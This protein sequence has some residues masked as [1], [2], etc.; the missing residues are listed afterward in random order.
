[1]AQVT[2]PQ[3]QAVA[4]VEQPDILGGIKTGMD[5]AAKS[6]EI[7]FR[8]EQLAEM[9]RESKMK[10]DEFN[11]NVLSGT[12]SLMEKMRGRSPKAKAAMAKILNRNLERMG[13]GL[14]ET[15]LAD[16]LEKDEGV[17][18]QVVQV[19]SELRE[20]LRSG[21]LTAEQYAEMG[22]KL[23]SIAMKDGGTDFAP[24]IK[25]V[26][27]QL[28]T[29]R[30]QTKELEKIEAKG[31][32]TRETAGFTEGLKRETQK[33]AQEATALEKEKDRKHNAALE[34]EKLSEGARRFNE[35]LH[36]RGKALAV[37][38]HK[39][40]VDTEFK[41]SKLNQDLRKELGDSKEFQS[42]SEARTEAKKAITALRSNTPFGDLS[43]IFSLVKVMDPGSV[44]RN[45]EVGQIEITGHLGDKISN[46]LNKAV[47][48]TRI[49][50]EEARNDLIGVIKDAW[51]ERRK[52]Y[53]DRRAPIMR[54]A[55]K[56]G[57]LDTDPGSEMLNEDN[58]FLEQMGLGPKKKEGKAPPKEE[59]GVKKVSD[60]PKLE[61]KQAALAQQKLDAM[62]VAIDSE[63]KS[64]NAN[65]QRIAEM[66]R[67]YAAAQARVRGLE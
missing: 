56:T 51:M 45:S 3:A 22:T 60:K 41:T 53:Q 28:S 16:L 20:A 64:A 33:Q 25:S 63:K 48:G 62:R 50:R 37:T 23:S 32:E 15:A 24:M 46:L 67:M 7:D 13:G 27:D 40:A 38:A 31:A 49:A 34:K 12:I 14:G 59:S 52:G 21:K 57:L 66:E 58:A 42:Y 61:P 11:T 19:G 5:F 44:V 55:K 9:Q 18:N 6:V 30:Q 4:K 1:M 65:P 43:A 47:K 54:Q 35:T 10:R 2:S 17:L 36:L 8:R 29:A 39:A 26:Q